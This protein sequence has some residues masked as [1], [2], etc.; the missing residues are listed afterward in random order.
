MKALNRPR[1][2]QNISC[3]HNQPRLKHV[4]TVSLNVMVT[5][6]VDRVWSAVIGTFHVGGRRVRCQLDNCT[7]DTTS[8]RTNGQRTAANEGDDDDDDDSGE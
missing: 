6:V 5:D 8:C 4:P 3:N 1:V 7:I 2:R